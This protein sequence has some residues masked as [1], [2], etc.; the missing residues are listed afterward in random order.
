MTEENEKFRPPVFVQILKV[1]DAG[2][3]ALDTEGCAW[4]WCENNS[5]GYYGWVPMN[6]FLL[7][8]KVV[9]HIQKKEQEGGA[10]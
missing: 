10:V 3:A 8:P 6:H 7:R 1:A 4:G 2:L 9:N 5:D